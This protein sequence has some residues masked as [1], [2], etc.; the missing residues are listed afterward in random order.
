MRP[1]TALSAAERD[2]ASWATQSLDSKNQ[3]LQKLVEIKQKLQMFPSNF[4]FPCT[5]GNSVGG[6]TTN[7]VPPAPKSAYP[8]AGDG[9]AMGLPLGIEGKSDPASTLQQLQAVRCTL[10]MASGDCACAH[11]FRCLMPFRQP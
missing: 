2:R 9:G 7:G 10:A 8:N 3:I 5:P 4:N 6:C 1:V 11:V